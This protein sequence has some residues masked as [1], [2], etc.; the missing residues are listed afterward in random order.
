MKVRQAAKMPNSTAT[1]KS[2]T[3]VRKNTASSVTR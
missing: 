2:N 3:T 1:V